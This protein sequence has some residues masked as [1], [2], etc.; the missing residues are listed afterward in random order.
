LNNSEKKLS[1]LDAACVVDGPA[2]WQEASGKVI[3]ANYASDGLTLPWFNRSS[4][5]YVSC[6][7]HRSL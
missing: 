5:G 3:Q 7:Q 1:T 2:E 6:G 4:S